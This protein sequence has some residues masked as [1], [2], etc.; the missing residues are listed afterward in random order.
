[1]CLTVFNN[2]VVSRGTQ[3]LV[4]WVKV[5]RLFDAIHP[6]CLLHVWTFFLFWMGTVHIC[7]SHCQYLSW[8]WGWAALANMATRVQCLATVVKPMYR[9]ILQMCNVAYLQLETVQFNLESSGCPRVQKWDK[10][11]QVHDSC[12]M[13][14]HPFW[15]THPHATDT[16]TGINLASASHS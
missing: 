6:P 5:L 13:Q 12:L 7:T 8:E 3:T 2:V 11:S 15:C 10:T 14:W 4:S 16:A 9:Q 1:M